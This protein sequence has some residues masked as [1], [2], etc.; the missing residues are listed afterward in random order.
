MLSLRVA[1]AGGELIDTVQV[2]RHAVGPE[3]TQLFVGSEG[4]LGIITRATLEIVPLP[5]ERRFLTLQFPNVDAGI[6]AFR[7]TLAAGYRPSVIRMYD[8]EATARTFSPVVGEALRGRLRR[9]V[10]RGRGRRPSPWRGP[11]PSSSHARW[12]RASSTLRSP[13]RWWDRRY[14]FYKPPHHPELPV[15]LGH[16]RRRRHLPQ[17][18]RRA[19][20]AEDLRA[21]PLRRPRAC[22]CGCTSRTGTAGAR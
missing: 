3:L 11:A 6:E 7:A 17:H 18:R 12:A 15:D 1:L 13:Q 8:E 4:T 19:R 2:P 20:G 14:E 10:L 22:S 16:D 5:P 9:R 21:R